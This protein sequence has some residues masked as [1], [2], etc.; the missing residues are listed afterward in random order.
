MNK[1]TR[2]LTMELLKMA[3]SVTV[4]ILWAVELTRILS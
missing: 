2:K 3:G 4:I 1:F